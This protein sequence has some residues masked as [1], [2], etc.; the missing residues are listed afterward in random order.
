MW[1]CEILWLFLLYVIAEPTGRMTPEKYT[2]PHICARF[3]PGG[4]LIKVMPNRPKEGQTATVEIHDI[5]T[6]LEDRPEVEELKCFPGPLVRFVIWFVFTRTGSLYFVKTGWHD[7][8]L[9]FKG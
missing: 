5:S 4:H 3:G 6:M 8:A 9:S 1:E 2:I 7:F